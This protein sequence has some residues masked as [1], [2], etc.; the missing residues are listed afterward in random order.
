MAVRPRLWAGVWAGRPVRQAGGRPYGPDRVSRGPSEV[1]PPPVSG[2]GGGGP[3]AHPLCDVPFWQSLFGERGCGGGK[4]PQCGRRPVR[5]AGG[6][7]GPGPLLP[8]AGGLRRAARRLAHRHR[9]VGRNLVRHWLA[10]CKSGGV[11]PVCAAAGAGA[12]LGKSIFPKRQPDLRAWAIRAKTPPQRKQLSA[13]AVRFFM[14]AGRRPSQHART[15]MHR[16]SFDQQQYIITSRYWQE[17]NG[18]FSK[19]ILRKM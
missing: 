17:G 7:G 9:P 13:E 2:W 5:A 15:N 11:H 16:R 6:P 1:L 18:I 3:Q 12:L 14:P 19:R 10:H 4:K 8:G